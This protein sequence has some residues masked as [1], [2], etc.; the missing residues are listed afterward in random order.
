MTRREAFAVGGLFEV[1]AGTTG[2]F[3]HGIHKINQH[4]EPRLSSH[5]YPRVGGGDEWELENVERERFSRISF[6]LGGSENA[7]ESKCAAA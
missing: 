3:T 1:W 6:P 5:P 2:Q 4:A 7:R